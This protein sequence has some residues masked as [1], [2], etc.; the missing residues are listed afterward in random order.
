MD[1]TNITYDIC[2]CYINDLVGTLPTALSERLLGYVRSR[3]F[4]K[5]ACCSELVEL[6]KTC[7]TVWKSLLQIEAFFKKNATMTE[8]VSAKLAAFISFEEGEQLCD[9]TNARLDAFRSEQY[10]NTDLALKIRKMQSYIDS[11]LGSH[12]DFLQKVPELIKFTSGAT[13][14]RSKRRALPFRKVDLRMAVTPGALRYLQTLAYSFGYDESN[15]GLVSSNRVEFVPKSWKTDR[16]IACEAEGNMLFQL[17][18]D[19]YLKGRLMVRGVNLFDQ[20]KNQKLANE[21]SISG[22]L[23]TIDLSMASDTLAYNAVALLFPS[24]WFSMLRAFRS[25]YGQVTSDLRIEYAKFSSMGNGATFT[26]E[27]LVFAAACKAVGSK[28]FSV[29]GDDIIIETELADELLRLLAFLGFVPNQDKSFIHGPF[30]ESC[31]KYYFGGVDVSPRFIRELDRRKA[32]ICHLVN[33]MAGIA[34]PWGH[35]WRYLTAMVKDY[36]LPLVPF[37]DNSMSGVWITPTKAYSLHLIRTKKPGKVSAAR[38]LKHREVG[39]PLV[40]PGCPW[41]PEFKGYIPKSRRFKNWSSRSLFLWYLCTSQGERP[42][43]STSRLPFRNA[44]KWYAVNWKK[45]SDH[46]WY[47]HSSHKYVRKWVHW[48]PPVATVAPEHLFW[49][50]EDISR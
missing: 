20:T 16:T 37:N 27:T 11:T 2:R 36:K 26:L 30:R 17:A 47:T 38:F 12:M 18:V 50:T 25:Q 8:P 5:L 15:F 33:T 4:E 34:S 29:Y 13:A 39:Q 7:S 46:S 23:A 24:R 41:I 40:L 49:W 28:R 6:D 10:E 45:L 22:D 3:S 35:L 1:A 19:K 32:T 42:V 43:Y 14:T 48:V 9:A 31:G 21:G 44:N